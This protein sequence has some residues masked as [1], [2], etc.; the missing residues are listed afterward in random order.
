M[1]DLID[2]ETIAHVA[3]L[4]GAARE[5]SRR[6]ALLSRADK[7]AALLAMADA[8]DL[9][10]GEIIVANDLDIVRGRAAGLTEGLLDRLRLDRPRVEAVADALRDIAGLPDP[11]GA[12]PSRTRCVRSRR[13]QTRSERSCAGRR[14]PTACRFD[15]CGC[16]WVSS[17]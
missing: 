12:R 15:R 16:R 5:A 10:S 11:V 9:A 14:W 2:S 3:E 6:L 4:A 1:A 17:P 7:D 8:L 13:S